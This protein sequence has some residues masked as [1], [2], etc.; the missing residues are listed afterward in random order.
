MKKKITGKYRILI[1]CL[2]YLALCFG[3]FLAILLVQHYSVLGDARQMSESQPITFWGLF[4]ALCT[5]MCVIARVLIFGI[6]SIV[7]FSIKSIS[8]IEALKFGFLFR[9]PNKWHQKNA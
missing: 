3:T 8:A 4:L 5:L 6:A 2:S 9:E 1:L 7:L